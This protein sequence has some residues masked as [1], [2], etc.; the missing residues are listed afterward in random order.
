M[1][2]RERQNNA[3]QETIKLTHI[4]V[5]RGALLDVAP[6]LNFGRLHRGRDCRHV[7]PLQV[8]RNRD[9]MSTIRQADTM[10]RLIAFIGS[11]KTPPPRR[12]AFDWEEEV[13]RAAT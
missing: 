4:V 9:H 12:R 6:S 8:H 5:T 13:T 3:Q 11:P 7:D 1:C 2:I 10:V